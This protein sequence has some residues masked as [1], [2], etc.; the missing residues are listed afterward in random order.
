MTILK[1]DNNMNKKI[2]YSKNE[3]IRLD[4]YLVEIIDLN[5]SQVKK[6]INEGMILLNDKKVKAGSIIKFDDKITV[7]EED[8]FILKP[9]KM[10]F[11]V[12]YE[13]DYIAVI[14][15]PQG[16]IVHPGAGNS[17]NTLVNGLLYTFKNLANTPDPLRPGIVHRL[18]KDTSGLM[19]IAKKDIAYINLVNSF[20]EHKVKKTYLAIVEGKLPLEGSIEMPIGRN[21]KNRIKMDVTSVNSK[22]AYTEYNSLKFFDNFT[23][24]SINL[25]TGRTHQ[26]RVHFKHIGHPIL[27]DLVY[28]NKNKYNINKQMLH[29]YKLEFKHPIIDKTITIEDDFPIRFE[30]FM[31]RFNYEEYNNG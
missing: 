10:N 15:K 22:Y 29:S 17:E 28:G 3:N 7:Y 11:I 8:E 20:K 2:Y 19:I 27:G 13:D 30:K 1:K 31:K 5:R 16:I 4:Q 14:S 26:I 25:F 9:K 18:D 6:K 24:A 21:I 12:K 23:L